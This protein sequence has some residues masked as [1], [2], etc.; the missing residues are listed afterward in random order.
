MRSLDRYTESDVDYLGKIFLSTA[1]VNRNM[2]RSLPRPSGPPITDKPETSQSSVAAYPYLTTPADADRRVPTLPAPR[3]H[4]GRRRTSPSF[5][6]DNN[7][8]QWPSRSIPIPR[9]SDTSGYGRHARSSSSLDRTSAHPARMSPE[10]RNILSFHDHSRQSR[11]QPKSTPEVWGLPSREPLPSISHLIP[12]EAPSGASNHSLVGP[13]WS[14]HSPSPPGTS[15]LATVG[16]YED[17]KAQPLPHSERASNT[18]PDV[19]APGVGHERRSQLLSR[20]ST[21]IDAPPLQRGVSE[22]GYQHSYH[23]RRD[24]GADQVQVTPEASLTR[25]P[26]RSESAT[27]GGQATPYLTKSVDPTVRAAP[28]PSSHISPQIDPQYSGDT[29]G[30]STSIGPH[31]LPRFLCKR[32]VADKGVCYFY[33]DGSHCKAVIDGEA[34]TPLWG[35]TKA[36]KPRKRLAVACLTCREKKIKCDP[37]DPKCV[38]CDKFG[39][40]CK[41]QHA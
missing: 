33:D 37:D 10:L 11:Q 29:I 40:V 23:N 26:H 7:T 30:S 5:S 8:A 31:S 22:V 36:G 14:V 20:T 18:H 3:E 34:V 41:F 6:T 4:H 13:P 21:F 15:S 38:Q 24:G 9:I 39:R 16:T 12:S 2:S 25:W 19:Y 35:V 27:S 1:A 32:F 28:S 17:V